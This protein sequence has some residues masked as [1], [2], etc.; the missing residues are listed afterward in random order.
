VLARLKDNAGA[1][2][3]LAAGRS[4]GLWKSAEEVK[5]FDL[6]RGVAPVEGAPA[7]GTTPG[8]P[9]APASWVAARAFW[10]KKA[11]EVGTDLAVHLRAHPFDLLAARAALRTAGP[12]DSEALSLAARVLQQPAMESLGETESDQALL[13]L[14]SAR[15]RLPS[16][17]RAASTALGPADPGSL[18]RD[19]RRRR[20]PSAEIQGVLADLARL[21]VRT[22]Q[23]AEAAVAAL[24][25]VR[26][27][28]AARLR[29]ELRELEKP[30]GPPAPYRL[31]AGRPAPYRPRDLDW[32]VVAA[33]LAA[34]GAQ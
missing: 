8:A 14:R 22:G 32:S 26:R 18:A 29:A 11:G 10:T 34:R 23:R 24:E 31:E 16:S 19:L 15:G 17:A 21:A 5:A 20:I 13:R 12:G 2:R 6:W 33:A 25:D 4:R 30:A 9:S 3:A 1:A 28:D 7:L 27:E